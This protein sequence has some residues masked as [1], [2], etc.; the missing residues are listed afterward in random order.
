MTKRDFEKLRMKNSGPFYPDPNPDIGVSP[1]EDSKEEFICN[2]PQ[3]KI[4][5]PEVFGHLISM[6]NL[7][8]HIGSNK[9]NAKSS[10]DQKKIF[11]ELRQLHET[12]FIDNH[13]ANY[14]GSEFYRK[15]LKIIEINGL[16]EREW[17]RS[18][19]IKIT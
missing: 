11:F 16:W 1:Y 7:L 10:E 14:Y 17:L 19:N 2:H 12:L 9:F 18:K 13:V 3:N 4:D 8:N 15:V 5:D 6:R